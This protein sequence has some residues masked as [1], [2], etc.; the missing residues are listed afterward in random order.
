MAHIACPL[1]LHLQFWQDIALNPPQTAVASGLFYSQAPTLAYSFLC[2]LASKDTISAVSCQISFYL[3]GSLVLGSSELSLW[4]PPLGW[5]ELQHCPAPDVGRGLLERMSGHRHPVCVCVSS[6][7]CGS[8]LLLLGKAWEGLEPEVCLW[9]TMFPGLLGPGM[10]ESLLLAGAV[11]CLLHSCQWHLCLPFP[12]G[13]VLPCLW[14]G[15]QWCKPAMAR[16]SLARTRWP[17]PTLVPRPSF[18]PGQWEPGLSCPCA[19]PVCCAMSV[20]CQETRSKPWENLAVDTGVEN[21]NSL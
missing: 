2:L 4:L 7:G 9:V 16:C 6:G 12:G 8:S 20:S 10:V 19:S 3:Q 5:A 11:L 21:I 15:S 13:A 14:F 18:D 1:Y 17:G